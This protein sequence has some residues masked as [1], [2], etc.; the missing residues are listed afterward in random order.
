MSLLFS[1]LAVGSMRLPNRIVM[2]PMSTDLGGE[3]GAVTERL[4]AYYEARARGG[5]GLVVSEAVTVDP[6]HP[7]MPRGLGLWDDGHIDCMRRLAEAVHAHGACLAPQIVHPG[8][9]SLSPL[10]GGPQPVGPSP[11]IRGSI[12][13]LECRELLLEEVHAMACLYA[14]AARRA[15]EAGCDGVEIHAAHGYM[16]LGSFLSPLRNRRT[17][18]Y[19]DLLRLPV[20]VI[21]A[22]R[23]STAP[24]FP[25]ILRI[26]GDDLTPGGRTLE[27]TL[28][29]VPDLERA[30]VSAFHVSAGTYPDS[31]SRVIPPACSP[32]C[33]NTHLSAAVKQRAGVPV[34]VVGRIT[35]PRLAEGVLERAEADLVVMGRSL[36]ADP[37]LPRKAAEGRFDDIAPCIGCGLGCIRARE[38]GGDL[39][40][41]VNPDCGRESDV[42]TSPAAARRKVVVVGGGPAG[43]EAARTAALRGHDVSLYESDRLGGRLGLAGGEFQRLVA[44]LST[45]A[46]KAGVAMHAGTI[47]TVPLV[48]GI[49]PD[50][51]VLATGSGAA[52]GLRS[53]I[54]EIVP[55]VHVI[56]DARSPRGALD[57]IAEGRE[58]GRAI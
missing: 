9:E 2:A 37:D 41:L 22:V 28:R 52:E 14:G 53:A 5:V 12:T 51:V 58:I 29:I 24:D 8:P 27:G 7:Y 19:G 56:G 35:D 4:L 15:L 26:S 11:G 3:D 34:M 39:T 40:C 25:I 10:F 30:G 49:S 23:E 31:A 36:L 16:L 38:Q 43:L 33:A 57:A 17:D 55:E 54:D 6:L 21:G 42:S 18:A 48:E 13:G 46:A 44:H 20:E 32:P 45:Q 1:P 47:V 50:V